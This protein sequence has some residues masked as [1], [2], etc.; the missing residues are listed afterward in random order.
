M[1][2]L[3]IVFIA[4]AALTLIIAAPL[5]YRRCQ[6]RRRE[7]RREFFRRLGRIK[8]EE[9]ARGKRDADDMAR[10]CRG[11]EALAGKSAAS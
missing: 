9:W 6:S 5:E 2:T 3:P 7:R 8:R 10:R 11:R 4:L 1:A